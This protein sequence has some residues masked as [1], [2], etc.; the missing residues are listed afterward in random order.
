MSKHFHKRLMLLLQ[1]LGL[2]GLLNH[3]RRL[4]R[5]RNMQRQVV[6]AEVKEEVVV[7]IVVGIGVA[8]FVGKPEHLYLYVS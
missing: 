2:V 1:Q 7:G 8:I 3:Q 5:T 4:Y 6:G